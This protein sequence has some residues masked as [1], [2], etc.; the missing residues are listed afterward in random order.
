MLDDAH[1]FV[2]LVVALDEEHH[3]GELRL[4]EQSVFFNTVGRQPLLAVLFD[5][6]NKFGLPDGA[7]RQRLHLLSRL[8]LDWHLG[9]GEVPCAIQV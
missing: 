7:G 2:Q 6:V 5:E 9:A 4:V 3:L 8:I 1:S